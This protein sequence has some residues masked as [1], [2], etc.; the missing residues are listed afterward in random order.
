MFAVSR[1]D[2]SLFA[3]LNAV[4][5]Q[6]AGNN[7]SVFHFNTRHQ[8]TV[9]NL[10]AFP[11]FNSGEKN[12]VRDFAV[13]GTALCDESLVDLSF[14]AYVMRKSCNVFGINLPGRIA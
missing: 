5:N 1:T 12:G 13:D 2:N 8:Y 3:D 10:G 6:S 9:D 4:G 14:S 11:N 7:G